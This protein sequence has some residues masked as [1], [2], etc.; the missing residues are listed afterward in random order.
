MISFLLPTAKVNHRTIDAARSAGILITGGAS[1]MESLQRIDH[2]VFDKT[3]TLT[4]GKLLV[5]DIEVTEKWQKELVTFSLL[6]CA[7]EESSASSHPVAEA[8]FKRLL[9]GNASEWRLYKQS[10]LSVRFDLKA[11]NGMSCEVDLVDG[12]TRR[13]VVGNAEMLTG[14]G[15]SIPSTATKH[16]GLDVFVA[17]DGD[18]S[19]CIRLGVGCILSLMFILT[20][21]L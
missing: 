15:I 18:C 1:T 3:G 13:V 11:G 5:H 19:G 17:V 12:S 20:E 8:V 14:A 2:V 6:V 9:Q 16:G 21:S 7:A 10:G 4:S